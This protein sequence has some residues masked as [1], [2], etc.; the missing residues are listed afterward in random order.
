MV[1]VQNATLA[2]GVAVGAV[3]NHYL[4]GGGAILIGQMM[5]SLFTSCSQPFIKHQFFIRT[6]G[7][8]AGAWSTFGYVKIMPYLEVR[9]YF[10]EFE[11]QVT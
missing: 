9:L 4:S 1:D 5:F 7:S 2:G 11:V 3:A 10:L 8:V 6:P